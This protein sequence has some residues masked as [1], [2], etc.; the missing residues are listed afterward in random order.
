MRHTTWIFILF[1]FLLF[2]CEKFGYHHYQVDDLPAEG[3]NAK[4][5]KRFI[6]RESDTITLAVIGDSQRFYESTDK[7]IKKINKVPGIDF[8]V[9]TGDLVDFGLQS[10]YEWMHEQLNRL[11]YPYVAVVGNHDLIGNGGDIY[12]KMYGDFNFSFTFNGYKFI[13]LNTNSREFD[14]EGNVPD[15]HWLDQQLADTA[16][17]E[18]AVIVSHVSHLN[19]DFND[20]LQEEFVQVLEKYEK[21]MLSINGHQHQFGFT[22]PNEQNIAFLNTYSTSKERFVL[23]KFWNNRFSFEIID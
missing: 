12:Q 22:P 4:N 6:D 19:P 5:I 9:H 13:Y 16:N 18:R 3:I 23:M 10:E 20:E 15:I 1:S 21:V 8:V 2:S 7:I 11:R 14:F 17:Y